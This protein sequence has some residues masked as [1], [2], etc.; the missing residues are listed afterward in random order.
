M[1][2]QAPS[3]PSPTESQ[4]VLLVYGEVFA[5]HDTDGHPENQHRLDAIVAHLHETG[6]WDRCQ[7]AEP[8]AATH[9]ELTTVH[10]PEYVDLVRSVSEADGGW[11]D[12]DTLISPGTY[13]AACH[14]AGAGL[15]AAER[16]L[17]GHMR[18]AFCLVRPPGHHARPSRGMGFCIFNNIAVTARWLLA[19]GLERLLIVDWDVPH[20]NGPE[21]TFYDDPRV[22]YLSLHLSP[23]YPGTGH[24]EDRGSGPGEGTTLNVPLSW[25]TTAEEYLSQFTPALEQ[26][27][28]R[29]QPQCILISAGFDAY[30]SDPIGLGLDVADFGRM[31]DLVVAQAE[32]TAGGRVL[33][34]LEGGYHPRGLARCVAEHLR[35]LAGAEQ[36]P[37]GESA[38]AGRESDGDEDGSGEKGVR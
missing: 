13:E 26:A 27:C 1:A 33:S 3:Q 9:D 7:V 18:R 16:L 23:F 12:Y 8:R 2:G 31:T 25:S 6:L 38:T 36:A 21:E 15:L 19:Q 30:R 35:R 37:T 29:C 17:A 14:A 22:F 32:A 20:G 5:R 24:L 11:L 10:D 34:M 4:P 28:A